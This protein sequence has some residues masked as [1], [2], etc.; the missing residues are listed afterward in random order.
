MKLARHDIYVSTQH[1][2]L[3]APS[4]GW[5]PE[6]TT[7]SCGEFHGTG[8]GPSSPWIGVNLTTVSYRNIYGEKV[9]VP[10]GSEMTHWQEGSDRLVMWKLNSRV[11][12]IRLEM[13]RRVRRI[14]EKPRKS[15]ISVSPVATGIWHG[16]A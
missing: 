5:E 3:N 8:R 2:R 14:V 12:I 4:R 1:E 10:A 11:R 13:P 15:A 6:I 9:S 7:V 16:R